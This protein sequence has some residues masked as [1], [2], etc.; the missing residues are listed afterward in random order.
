MNFGEIKAF[1]G[2]QPQ[3][4][5]PSTAINKQLQAEG[6]QQAA[7]FQA[8]QVAQNNASSISV[9]SS[10][11][12]V[13]L[14]IYSSSM[15]QNVTIDGERDAGAKKV[16]KSKPASLF[17]FEKVAENVMR[18]VGGV[19]KGAASSGA[20]EA[21][22]A[23]L[24]EQAKSGVAKGIAMAERDIGSFMNEEIKE[25]ITRSRSLI[26]EQ[27]GR[28]EQNL[29]GKPQQNSDQVQNVASLQ[30]SYSQESS[31]ELTIRTKDGDEVSLQF[32]DLRQASFSTQSFQNQLLNNPA[33]DA[34]EQAQ[35]RGSDSN[36]TAEGENTSASQR[37]NAQTLEFSG[38]RVT[39]SGELD[40]NELTAIGNLVADATDLADTFYRGD[41]ETAFNQALE[42]GYDKQELVGYALQLNRIEKA[43]VVKAYGYVQHFNE[44]SASSSEQ[45]KSV[46]P[47]AQYLD[48]MLAV[49]EQSRQ[50][51]SSQDDY[52]TL[53]NGIV[54]EMKDVQV[55]DLVQAINRFHSFNQQL[56]EGLPKSA[57][58]VQ[59]VQPNE[60]ITN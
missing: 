39:V 55:P 14:K 56:I 16:D 8:K 12:T 11:T 60:P 36:D 41:I 49:L 28:L 32:V 35:P 37:S 19:I 27:I 18:F 53:M 22:L 46:K 17:D 6:L 58:P 23:S 48:K 29:L 10:Q 33:G 59:P 40:Q 4:A 42:L 5:K 13:G 51:L 20:D 1:M 30:A 2:D 25:G 57:P 31:G 3:A 21:K 54:N 47:V 34:S 44:Q 43:E 9:I 45:E 24:F 26:G 38:F 50:T 7:D 52:N 15:Q